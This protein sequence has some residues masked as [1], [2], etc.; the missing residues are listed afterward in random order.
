MEIEPIGGNKYFVIFINDTSQKLWVYILRT[1]DQVFQ[2]FQK[3]HAL[4]ERETG[5]KLK[6]LRTDNEVSTLQE[7]LKSTVQTME[8]DMKRQFLEP[9][10]TMV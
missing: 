9:Q 8:P 10:H 2:V 6:R 3:F 5:R 4:I 1:K 7:N